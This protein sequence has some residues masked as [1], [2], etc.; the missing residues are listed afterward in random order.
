MGRCVNGLTGS[1][2]GKCD[3]RL[4]EFFRPLLQAAA[5]WCRDTWTC[6]TV[7]GDSAATKLQE[8][9]RRESQIRVVIGRWV[10]YSV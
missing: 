9:Q 7:G 5:D 6:W 4:Q 1:G 2:Y 10:C 8:N 3:V